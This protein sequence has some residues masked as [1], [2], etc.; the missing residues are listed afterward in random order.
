MTSRAG[1]IMRLHAAVRPLIPASNCFYCG[2]EVFKRG[3]IT[4]AMQRA[5]N[6]HRDSDLT[7]DHILPQN[8]VRG[9]DLSISWKQNNQ[10][11]CCAACNNYKGRLM[12]LDWLVIMPSHEGATRLGKR[13]MELGCSIDEV[14]SAMARRKKP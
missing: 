3:N 4:K 13:L 5:G 9:Q 6:G 1:E 11:P 7:V 8:E 10:V 12:P 2:C 14:S